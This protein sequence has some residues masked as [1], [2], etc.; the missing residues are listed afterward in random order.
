MTWGEE[1]SSDMLEPPSV[2]D[3]S[4]QPNLQ[5]RTPLH[6][7]PLLIQVA[8]SQSYSCNKKKTHVNSVPLISQFFYQRSWGST[9]TLGCISIWRR[10]GSLINT[11]WKSFEPAFFKSQGSH[12]FFINVVSS[13]FL[14]QH[15]VYY[16][17][18][19]IPG[20]SVGL[21]DYLRPSTAPHTQ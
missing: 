9:T 2:Q 18:S 11:I 16:A 21:L 3:S 7:N 19:A 5:F 20:Q 6:F 10:G 12:P 4:S 8:S 13:C 15:I 14:I 17:A 1:K